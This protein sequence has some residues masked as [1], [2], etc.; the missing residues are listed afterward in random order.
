MRRNRNQKL[1]LYNPP[2]AIA[3]AK[4]ARGVPT[5]KRMRGPGV[6]D[7]GP[8][9]P[10]ENWHESTEGSSVAF[11]VVTQPAGKGYRHAVT[12]KEVRTRLAE[13]PAWM[14]HPLDVVQIS[15]MTRKKET[16]PCYG[17]QWGS[18][19]YLY[20]IEEGL[21]EEFYRPPKPLVFNEARMF[22]GR[23]EQVSNSHWRL[24]WTPDTLRDFYLNNILIHELGHL[25]DERNTGYTDRERYAEWFAIE[26][27]YKPSRRK[28]LSTS[29]RKRRVRRR[30]HLT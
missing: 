9:F 2:G 13:L 10:T 19:L 23:W 15:R 3:K 4:S 28:P 25:L 6:A 17:M 21:V 20:P 7:R 1:G 24:I 12:A 5:S 22:G 27:G 11:R 29:R 16:F 18:S 8:F 26:I 30:H 14:L